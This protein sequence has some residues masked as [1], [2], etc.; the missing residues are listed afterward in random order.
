MHQAAGHW[1]Q[2]GNDFRRAVEFMERLPRLTADNLYDLA[3]YQALLSGVLQRP[4]S[5]S[6]AAEGQAAADRA[7]HRLREAVAAGFRDLAHM[8]T[9]TDLDPLRSRPDFQAPDDGPRFPGRSVCIRQLSG[10]ALSA[11]SPRL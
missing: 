8:R 10:M 6:S 4:G 2:A 5:G 9:D 1:A 11:P 3:C 7:M